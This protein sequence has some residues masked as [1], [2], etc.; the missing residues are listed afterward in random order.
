MSNKCWY[1]TTIEF[2][3]FFSKEN[4]PFIGK[5]DCIK[6]EGIWKKPL[7]EIFSKEWISYLKDL[8]LPLWKNVLLFYRRPHYYAHRGHVDVQDTSCGLNWIIGGKDSEMIWYEMPK[9]DR[10]IKTSIAGTPYLSWP[11]SEMKEIERHKLSN[12][13]L[14][15][16]RVDIP[17][18]IVVRNDDRWCISV[19]TLGKEFNSWDT[20]VDYF[21]SKNLL[22]DRC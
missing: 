18:A 5:N 12:N 22:E 8:P 6:Q 4:L 15:L 9:H 19:R 2:D 10:Q 17:H 3:P 11:V 20:T 16:V 21:K 7:E 14:T 13:K 1:E